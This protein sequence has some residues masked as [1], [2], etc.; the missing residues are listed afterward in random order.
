MTKELWQ[1][2]RKTHLQAV[3]NERKENT[4]RITF[5]QTYPSMVT[6]LGIDRMNA[7]RVPWQMP[8]PKSWLTKNRLRYEVISLIDFTHT[9]H[10][11]YHGLNCFPHDSDTTMTLIYFKLHQLRQ[12]GQ[13]TPKL[14]LHMDNC[15]RENKNRYVFAFCCMLV[16]IG[17]FKEVYL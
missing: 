11:L 4:F 14:Q 16:H 2:K 12:A 9:E 13:I 1:Q 17:W 10:Q 7:I 15:F 8:F 6:L 3:Y 5:S